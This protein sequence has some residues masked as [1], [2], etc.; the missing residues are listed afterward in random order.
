MKNPSLVKIITKILK[1]ET[2]AYAAFFNKPESF[3]GLDIGQAAIKLVQLDFKVD[4]PS[5]I[6]TSLVE[7]ENSA[8]QQALKQAVSG[9]E[10][11]KV[12]IISLLNCPSTSFKRI[13][14]PLMNPDE[15]PQALRWEMKK[16]I[17]SP[18]EEMVFNFEI[19]SEVIDK[20]IKKKEVVVCFSPKNTVESHLSLLK[21]ANLRPASLM[22]LPYVM[23]NLVRNSQINAEGTFAVIE[24]GAL[25]TNLFIFENREL[26]F[27]RR[28][29]ITG[30]D[31]TES[32]T[33]VLS[34]EKE[35]SGLS[36][37]EAEKLKRQGGISASGKFF[38][39]MRP[40][41][42]RLSSEIRRSFDYYLEKLHGSAP[43]KLFISGGA[44]SLKGLTEFLETEL[45]IDVER[46][47]LP[48][49]EDGH[50]FNIAY[51]LALSR[52]E[53]I[54]LLPQELRQE[55]QRLIKRTLFKIVIVSISA[56]LFL[57]YIGMY[58]QLSSY[59]KRISG[60][61]AQ[62]FSLRPQIE[63]V[64]KA[65]LAEKILSSR[66]YWVDGLKEISNIVPQEVYLTRLE[67]DSNKLILEGVVLPTQLKSAREI[68]SS[69][70]SSLGR[71]MFKNVS[72]S[73]VKKEAGSKDA[74][75]FMIVCL[76]R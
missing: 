75:R 55:G 38:V 18:V 8:V 53:G 70:V 51:G 46:K 45:G 72:V 17:P 39:L 26:R 50:H 12:A 9:L 11:Q 76:W 68:I 44:S 74:F 71:G 7:I 13:L 52:A 35:V 47:N 59:R 63:M 32:L 66:P 42:E 30:N 10:L 27:V 64:R 41:L 57:F 1:R 49:I 23:E 15:I 6:K 43:V 4:T 28:L 62:I 69:F 48:G 20:G 21:E 56:L 37:K 22:C 14:L 33:T 2:Q 54:N 40:V 29:P 34:T 61:R 73:S 58:V 67:T 36:A 24:M 3:V 5:L 16:Y 65:Q 25:N 31:F 60:L 19:R